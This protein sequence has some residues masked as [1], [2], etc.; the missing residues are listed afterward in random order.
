ME[1]GVGEMILLAICSTFKMILEY[2]SRR[3]FFCLQTE[4]EPKKEKDLQNGR[5][6]PNP[7]GLFFCDE[8]L[9]EH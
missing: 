9:H 7:G 1:G 4:N 3:A 8:I 5:K 6:W 2:R